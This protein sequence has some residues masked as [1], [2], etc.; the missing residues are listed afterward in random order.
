MSGLH[1]EETGPKIISDISAFRV[2]TRD[3]A[4]MLLGL[5]GYPPLPSPKAMLYHFL[6]LLLKEKLMD[7]ALDALQPTRFPLLRQP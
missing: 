2:R 1:V 6:L 7:Y 5:E 4:A 3:L